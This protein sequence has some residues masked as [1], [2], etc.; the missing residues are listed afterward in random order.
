VA[1]VVLLE[2]ETNRNQFVPS[3]TLF[4]TQRQLQQ[5]QQ[6]RQLTLEKGG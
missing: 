1:V 5:Q 4:T 6:Q 2:D 3:H